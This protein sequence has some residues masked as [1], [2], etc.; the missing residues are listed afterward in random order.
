SQMLEHPLRREFITTEV[1]NQLVNG[2]GITYWMRLT[3]ETGQGAAELTRAHIVARESF[4][5]AALRA[6]VDA[7]DIQ[8]AASAQTR[9]RIEMRTLVES[10]SRWLIGRYP[11]P[12]DSE[13]IVD[14]VSVPVQRL[15]AALPEMLPGVEHDAF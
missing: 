4:G 2:A 1:V 9:M 7:L 8:L 11:S 5:V 6:E 15:M 13:K 10:A 3:A 12:L 14:S